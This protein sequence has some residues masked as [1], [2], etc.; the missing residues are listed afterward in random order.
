MKSFHFEVILVYMQTH[1]HTVDE[2]VH[3]HKQALAWQALSDAK[4]HYLAAV[5]SNRRIAGWETVSGS[6]PSLH[7]CTIWQQE[8]IWACVCA[9]LHESED[10]SESE[11]LCY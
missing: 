1:T 5:S 10:V 3:K 4:G 11:G 2:S 8:Q 9:R 6:A 7:G